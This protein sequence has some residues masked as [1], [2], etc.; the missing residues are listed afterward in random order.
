MADLAGLDTQVFVL[1]KVC[2]QPEGSCAFDA[3]THTSDFCLR[4]EHE[5]RVEADS[6]KPVYVTLTAGTAEVFG[7]CP[8]R[9]TRTQMRYA[10]GEPYCGQRAPAATAV[11]QRAFSLGLGQ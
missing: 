2:A 1:D 3:G 9:Q 7:E 4:Q 8:L 11:H 5:L 6:D 10:E